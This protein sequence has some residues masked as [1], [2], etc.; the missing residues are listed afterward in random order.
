MESKSHFR[1]R[2]KKFVPNRDKKLID[3]VREC[4]RYYHYAYKTEQSYVSWILRYVK[5]FGGKTHPKKLSA[6]D[7]E[8][9]LSHL[10]SA[11]NVAAATQR[12]ALNAIAF[13]Y[14]DVLD[15]PL[16][17]NIAPIRSKKHPRPPTVMTEEE[18]TDLLGQMNGLH[19]LMA[20]I[21]YGGGLR[22]MEC[23]RL[24]IQDIDLGQGHIFVRGGKGNKDR[25][26]LLPNSLQESLKKQMDTVEEIHTKDLVD[27]YGEVWLPHALSKKYQHAGK[28]IGWQYLFPSKKL[29]ND[30]RSSRIMRH[31]VMES[32]IQKAVKLAAKNAGLT[33]RITCHTLRH[34]FATHMLEHGVNIRTLQ[35]LLGHADVKTTEIYTH[36]MNTDINKLVSPLDQLKEK[37]SSPGVHE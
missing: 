27:G 34:S 36:V 1:D 18:V 35:K 6:G 32:G 8:K 4:L 7:V 12:Q 14:R 11:E 29:S 28:E 23:I 33:K 10:A 24:R 20:N 22:L 2:G 31:H 13:L 30:P 16:D 3:Q 9:Y 21:M 19:L 25:T 15:L 26:T 37:G 17:G 5:F